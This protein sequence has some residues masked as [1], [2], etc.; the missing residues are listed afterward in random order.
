MGI[1]FDGRASGKLLF[2]T[3]PRGKLFKE[4]CPVSKEEETLE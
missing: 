3:C 1:A 4:P 2:P